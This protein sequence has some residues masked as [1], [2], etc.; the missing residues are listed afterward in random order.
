MTDRPDPEPR[1]GWASDFPEFVRTPPDL[2]R[3]SLESFVADASP[4]QMRAWALEI[5]AGP[6]VLSL[7]STAALRV[8]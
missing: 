3:R 1:Y 8:P 7:H 5:G 4:E 6:A 2:V